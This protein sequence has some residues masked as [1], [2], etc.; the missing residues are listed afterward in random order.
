MNTTPAVI[1]IDIGGTKISGALVDPQL[2]ILHQIT[3]PSREGV[4]G[5]ADPGLVRTHGVITDLLDLAKMHGIEVS[6]GAAG[7]PEYVTLDG[8]LTTRD[9]I[10]WQGQPKQEF[11]EISGFPW[12]IE[13]DVRCAGT[14]EARIGAGKDFSDFVY[15]T[16]SSGISHT[17]FLGGS[18]QPGSDGSAIGFGVH[19]LLLEGETRS[20]E[21][22]ASGLGIARRYALVSGHDSAHA[23]EVFAQ[24]DTDNDA[25]RI[26]KSAAEILGSEI[27]KFAWEMRT[28]YIVIGGGLWLGSDLYRSLVRNAFNRELQVRAHSAQ[29]VEA[30]V[31]DSGVIGAAIYAFDQLV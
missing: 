22:Y 29:I 6:Q 8:S 5:V 31:A 30:T 25:H 28:H 17:H 9:N 15:I 18:A 1:A 21:S 26:V 7:F 3:I 23:P 20:L 10:D 27:A 16:V 13:S 14:A 2:Q 4:I 24:Y 12:I 11:A 19:E